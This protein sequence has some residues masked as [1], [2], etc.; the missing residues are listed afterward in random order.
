MCRD[1][2]PERSRKGK[3]ASGIGLSSFDSVAGEGAQS[4]PALD[5]AA[6]ALR[7]CELR[8]CESP[9]ASI[10]AFRVHAFPTA[11]VPAISTAS[12]RGQ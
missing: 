3:L 7:T 5:R 1:M 6:L 8:I 12:A 9:G 4:D 2:L 11:L 10:G